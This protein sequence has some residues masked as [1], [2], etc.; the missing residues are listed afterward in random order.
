[1]NITPLKDRLENWGKYQRGGNRAGAGGMHAKETRSASPHG[2][3]GYKCMT[4]VICNILATS[5]TGP[6][7]WRQSVP[8]TSEE[9][10]DAKLVTLAYIT[11]KDRAKDVLRWC[12]VLNAQPAVI[13]R[14]LGIQPWP[15][16]NFKRELEAAEDGIAKVLDS[17]S[18]RN[19]IPTNNLFPSDQTSDVPTGGIADCGGNE[20]E[21]LD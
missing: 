7:G 20:K 5:A 3:Q 21:A 12:Y 14:K 8:M 1:M 11:L 17:I 10:A 15:A 9:I 16:S 4:G 19:T 18:Q 13:C 2:G 6:S